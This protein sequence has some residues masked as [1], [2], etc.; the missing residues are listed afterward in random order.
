MLGR[1]CAPP[2]SARAI[3]SSSDG[4]LRP[5]LPRLRRQRHDAALRSGRD[6]ASRRASPTP[7]ARRVGEHLAA[8]RRRAARGRPPS[9][10]AADGVGGLVRAGR[11]QGARGVLQ[12]VDR[13]RVYGYALGAGAEPL[14]AQLMAEGWRSAGSPPTSPVA[15]LRPYGS[16]RARRAGDAARRHLPRQR[17]P[18]AQALDRGAAGPEPVGRRALDVGRQRLVAPAADGR[19]RRHAGRAA[20]RRAP[21]AAAP[22]VAGGRSRWRAGAWRCWPTRARSRRSSPGADAAQ[23]RHELGALRPRAPGRAGRRGRRRGPRRR[24]A[25]RTRRLR[26]GRRRAG[27]ALGAGAG[28]GLRLR[29]GRRDVRRLARPR[30]SRWRAPPG[31]RRRRSHPRR[32]RRPGSPA[33]RS[34]SAAA[35]CSTTTTRSSPAGT[36]SPPTARVLSGWTLGSPAGRPAIL[37]ERVGAGRAVLFAFDPVFRGVERERAGAAH[38]CSDRRHSRCSTIRSE[39]QI[40]SPSM[41]EQR[42]VALAAERS[43]SGA[44]ALA[45]RHPDLLVVDAAPAQLARDAPARAQP[46]GRGAAAVERRAH[47][48]DQLPQHAAGGAQA[49]AGGA[50][51]RAAGACRARCRRA[52][53]RSRYQSIVVCSV[54]SWW[55]GLPA[56]LALGLRRA[57]RPPQRRGA[58][59]D[60]R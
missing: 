29:R 16:R 34:P 41:H 9:R 54:S 48:A 25:G 45:P 47:G 20:A 21:A 53:S 38:G 22:A 46:V 51:R 43:T 44:V 60:R 1:R 4:T 18:A 57:E 42:H 35:W 37:D 10:R 27:L 12:H 59:L 7:Y 13:P 33:R 39:S 3:A 24:R 40:A 30:A 52:G 56:E 17:R 19:R 49:E 11:Q 28:G 32:G 15:S 14:V 36:S 50:Q 55:A 26:G 2:S 31:S 58:H 8:A 23:R 5:A 6:D